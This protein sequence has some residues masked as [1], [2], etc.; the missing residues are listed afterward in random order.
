MDLKEITNG[1]KKIDG[2]L[3]SL[4]QVKEFVGRVEDIKDPKD[5]GRVK[6]R[7]MGVHPQ[8]KKL[9]PTKD[10]IWIK[11]DGRIGS[12][13]GLGQ[14]HP[15]QANQMVKLKPTNPSMSTW[16]VVGGALAKV[17][18]LIDPITKEKLTDHNSYNKQVKGKE[19]RTTSDTVLPKVCN[20]KECEGTI[21][22]E[23]TNSCMSC[24]T[25]GGTP[26]PGNGIP[27]D[28]CN[29]NPTVTAKEVDWSYD[30][31]KVVTRFGDYLG[32]IDEYVFVDDRS[33][34]WDFYKI[35]LID[36][37]SG[38]PGD[39]WGWDPDGTKVPPTYENHR[40]VIPALVDPEPES[41]PPYKGRVYILKYKIY[42]I[43][44]PTKF[45]ENV[46][47][48]RVVE[49]PE[50]IEYIPD[51]P[52][53]GLPL[54]APEEVTAAIGPRPSCSPSKEHKVKEPK[55]PLNKGKS[56]FKYVTQYPDESAHVKDAT[57][58]NETWSYMH[59]IKNGKISRLE[60][61]PKGE[62][63]ARSSGDMYIITHENLIQY[64]KKV[65]EITVK[66]CFSVKAPQIVLKGKVCCTGGLDV[67]GDLSVGGSYPGSP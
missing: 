13:Q 27:E 4:E 48:I 29:P 49:N 63:I 34:D 31:E 35:E 30:K 39:M 62:F 58:G 28:P 25:G 22:E 54:Q 17:A 16:E 8:S 47:K 60:F 50:D 23:C 57:P 33:A 59:K 65:A 1:I 18:D 6:V 44:D 12:G 64:V 37:A 5:L 66:Q 67:G 32:S 36:E 56:W 42:K 52:P 24:Y 9:L 41:E 21:I 46:I 26:P 2:L 55:S 38:F 43:D 7:I 45:D 20:A 51:P 14:V 10:L 15:V 19:D 11:M 3:D 61:T 40:L 53:V